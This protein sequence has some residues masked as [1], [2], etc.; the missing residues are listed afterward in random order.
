[1]K[2]QS[3]TGVSRPSD[4]ELLRRAIVYAKPGRGTGVKLRWS[5]IMDIFSVGS[6][7]AIILCNEAGVD[8]HEEMVR[9]HCEGCLKAIFEDGYKSSRC[10]KNP[11]DEGTDEYRHWEDGYYEKHSS[12]LGL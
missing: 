8:P 4:S 3:I 5:V 12:S 9:D 11:Y 2:E 7:T 10:D 6:T 1:M